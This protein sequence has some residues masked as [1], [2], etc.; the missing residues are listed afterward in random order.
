MKSLSVRPLILCVQL[1][2]S[3]FP[4]ARKISG[5]CPC[6]SA[7]FPTWLTNLRASRK[8]G[9]LK[10]FVMWCSSITFH[11][12]TCFCREAS[13]SPCSGGT[14][15]RHGTQ[16]LVAR[17]D[18]IATILALGGAKAGDTDACCGHGVR[19]GV[20]SEAIGKISSRRGPVMGQAD[21][22]RYKR[23]LLEKRRDLSSAQGEAQSRVPA[24]GG[25]QGDM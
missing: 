1:V 17:S 19:V 2:I 15:P 24:A 12:S 20:E 14:L 23:L 8:S 6:S 9:N 22:Q 25:L 5:W 3:T 18:I 11:P 13:S 7:R 10:A 16:V 21:L 4:Q